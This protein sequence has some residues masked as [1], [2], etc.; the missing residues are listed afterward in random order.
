MPTKK[1]V[2]N[3]LVIFRV[4]TF[5]FVIFNAKWWPDICGRGGWGAAKVPL[6][7][8]VGEVQNL[9]FLIKSFLDSPLDSKNSYWGLLDFVPF[10]SRRIK[11]NVIN[12]FWRVGG[13]GSRTT[14]IKIIKYRF[15]Q[16]ELFGMVGGGRLFQFLFTV[17]IFWFNI[18]S[19]L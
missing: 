4:R 7:R 8:H 19:V 9:H 11:F 3:V 17:L 14:K 5:F 12:R 16:G 13:E 1:L 2:K 15:I 10:K 18:A 6:W